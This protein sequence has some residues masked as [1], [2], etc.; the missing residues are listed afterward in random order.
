MSPAKKFAFSFITIVCIP[1]L[2]FLALEGFLR[3]VG[4]G[5]HYDYFNE[6][7]IQ[8]KLHFQENKSFA[9]QFYPPSLGVAPLNNTLKADRDDSVVRVYILGG[10]AAQGFPHINH[11]LDR[12]LN[13]HLQ[14]A[15]PDKTIEII[16]TAMTS[17]NSHVVYEVART[18]PANSAEYAII[19][20]GNNEVVG[21]Y[22]PSTFSQNFLSSLS[23]I[24]SLQALK[25]TRIWQVTAKLIH[26]FQPDAGKEE[27]EW[28]GMQMF[29]EFTVTHDDHR[30]GDVYNHYESN[31][32]DMIEILQ[33]KKMHVVLS[34]VP[35]NTRHSAPF[36]SSHKNG[37]TDSQLQQWNE[38][39]Q[40]A[41][42]V[43]TQKDWIAAE[44]FY[45]ALQDID[46]EY[47]DSHFRL[48]TVLEKRGNYD[49]AKEH[50][51]AALH[52]DTKRF[53]S[54]HVINEIIEA[55]AND[56]TSEEL[57]YVD[58]VAVFNSV[59]Q[60]FAPG[61]GL[62]HEHV[63]FDYDGNYHLARE[64]THAIMSDLNLSENYV[65]PE[66]YQAA[67]LIGFP[68]HE[69]IQ[70]MDRLLSMVQKPPFTYQS[71]YVELEANTAA[72]R[73]DIEKQ[74]GHPSDVIERRKLIVEQG[75]ADWKIHYELAELNSFLRDKDASYFHL[76]ELIKLYPHNHEAYIKLAE[77]LS[78]KNELS[79]ANEYLI[80]SLYYTRNDRK[81]N[82]Q[83]LG[84]LGL[85][86]MKTNNYS[87]GKA[88]LEQVT[89]QFPEQ[90]SATIRAYGA[91]I[92]YARENK[93]KNDFQRYVAAVQRYALRIIEDE[94]V[95]EFPLLY[96]R[97]AQVMTIAG[98][99]AEA[100]RWQS[101]QSDSN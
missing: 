90:I 77:Y 33:D 69:T 29:S 63:H 45:R 91:L 52:Y 49:Q 44:K 22:G 50:F 56:E 89:D 1:A 20:M 23:L 26:K 55:V 101:M 27:I 85:N 70:V 13:A 12:H 16:N 97:M 95:H 80:Q 67:A 9:N 53:R 46:S 99:I 31:L 37:I 38:L 4:L 57:T 75:L 66:K 87:E 2:F 21:P 28:Q 35:V 25:R 62:L 15:L 11:G 5:T 32:R 51:E 24:R 17:V 88:Y 6:I 48:A 42:E 81:K 96:R 79:L 78:A 61:W 83:A 82:T 76:T 68:N 84:W 3:L 60:P 43:F 36:G 94:R 10:S 30:L 40:K 7:D 86:Y 14:A 41:D 47:A 93:Q 92:K 19:L 74:V 71:N 64:F 39:N 65:R 8:G 72:R 73:N 18:L 100:Q 34:S 98:D 58:N 54:N 59:S